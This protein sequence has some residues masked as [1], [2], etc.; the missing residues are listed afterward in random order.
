MENQI[1]KFQCKYS[2]CTYGE[3]GKRKE[4]EAC[5]QCFKVKWWK[6][7]ACCFE[8]YCMYQNEVAISRNQVIP[9]PE[10]VDKMIM[11]NVIDKNTK[12]KLK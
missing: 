4:Y 11:D 12:L 2:G 8:H 10:Y 7:M 9:F 3:D 1:I 6:E 5:L